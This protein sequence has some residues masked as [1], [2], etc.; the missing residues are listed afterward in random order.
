[1]GSRLW[2]P[3]G[4]GYLRF[5][6]V[7][8]WLHGHVFWFEAPVY[9]V[10]QVHTHMVLSSRI[11]ENANKFSMSLETIHSSVPKFTAHAR[12]GLGIGTVRFQGVHT[13]SHRP[14][15][16]CP[17]ALPCWALPAVYGVAGNAGYRWLHE[18]CHTRTSHARVLD[19]PYQV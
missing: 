13:Y 12:Q 5:S 6:S 10:A 18:H 17:W 1:M 9:F 4:H 16:T 7:R 3:E 11:S 8:K 14:T 19:A 15:R 2:I